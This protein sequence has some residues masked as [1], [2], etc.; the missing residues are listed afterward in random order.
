MAGLHVSCWQTQPWGANIP[1]RAAAGRTPFGLEHVRQI[2][3]KKAD[4]GVPDSSAL[5]GSHII[6]S[7]AR[8]AISVTRA[9]SIGALFVPS[10]GKK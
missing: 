6:L 7:L 4:H 8:P 5:S 9:L 10:T 1:P 2:C 3:H